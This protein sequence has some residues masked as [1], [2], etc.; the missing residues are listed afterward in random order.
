M[1]AVAMSASYSGVPTTAIAFVKPL[2]WGDFDAP[3]VWGHGTHGDSIHKP[4]FS[5][6]LSSKPTK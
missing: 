1:A 6:E 5:H 3:P 4:D 2:S